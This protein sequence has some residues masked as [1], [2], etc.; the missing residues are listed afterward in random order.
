MANKLR[1]ITALVLVATIVGSTGC[2]LN[3]RDDAGEITAIPN[4]FIEAISAEDSDAVE[5]ITSKYNYELETEDYRNF[6]PEVFRIVNYIISL[7]EIVDCSEPEIN[8]KELTSSMD[9]TFSYIDIGDFVEDMDSMYLTEEEYYEV[10]DAYE[11]R[12]EKT[13]TLDFVY[14]E[15]EEAWLLKRNSAKKIV[16]L[17][18]SY[19][20]V[21][22]E[23]QAI[24][25]SETDDMLLTYLENLTHSDYVYITLSMTTDV[26]D[27]FCNAVFGSENVWSYVLGYDFIVEYMSYILSHDYVIEHDNYPYD[28]RFIGSAPSGEDLYQ[29]FYTDEFRTQFYMNYIRYAFLDM[30]DYDFSSAQADLVIE[31]FTNAI[32]DCSPEPYELYANIGELNDL[33]SHVNIIS[34][35]FNEPERGIFE[36]EHGATIE[37]Q[38]SGFT[39][40]ADEL[41]AIGEIDENMYEELIATFTPEFF[42][43]EENENVSPSGHPDQATGVV[44]SV[45]WFAEDGSLVY[46]YSSTDENGFWMFYSKEPGWLDTVGYY[47][48]EEGIWITTYFDRPFAE[49]TNLIV[50]WWV[51]EEQ[52]VDT[53]IVT[54][55][56]DGA[57]VVEVYL[58]T[59]G[60]P[61]NHTYEMRLW[62]D[63]HSHVIAYV[64]LTNEMSY[65]A[66]WRDTIF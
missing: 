49:G 66:T 41:Y 48:D 16:T 11:D 13:L 14:D 5:S 39:M 8:R 31:T 26:H 18:M 15:E 63:N 62:E 45:P 23:P 7:T 33:G 6:S 47:V 17:F 51:D 57:S 55:E 9:V 27:T 29:S 44:E 52:V 24:S 22:P 60:F 20:L 36:F 61:S 32:A 21:L 19:I 30:S 59:T 34:D 54:I 65:A 58:P 38:I 25:V 46:G 64:T 1:K 12:E 3:K 28:L 50:D 2:S 53:Q 40:A 35:L 10:I 43:Y 56:E 42:G 37:D 4:A